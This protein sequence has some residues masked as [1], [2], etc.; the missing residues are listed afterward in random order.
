METNFRKV[1][2]SLV[3]AIVIGLV[4]GYIASASAIAVHK[5]EID[6]IKLRQDRQEARIDA[7][8][9]RLSTTNENLAGVAAML[10]G[11]RERPTGSGFRGN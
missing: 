9:D 6:A 1:V 3:S 4:S 10:N 7:I 2:L 11:M 5:A 8:L